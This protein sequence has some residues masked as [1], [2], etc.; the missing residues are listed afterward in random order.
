M[1]MN[2]AGPARYLPEVLAGACIVQPCLNYSSRWPRLNKWYG[3]VS[4]G[5]PFRCDDAEAV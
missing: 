3:D 1:S 5:K 2:R 4:T